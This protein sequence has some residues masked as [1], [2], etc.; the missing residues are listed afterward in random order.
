MSVKAEAAE[1]VE[2]RFWSLQR[3]QVLKMSRAKGDV[4]SEIL[5][6]LGSC[7]AFSGACAVDQVLAQC[8]Q[9][10]LRGGIALEISRVVR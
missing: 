8:A 4:Q 9:G 2:F 3:D 5:R 1:R 7:R 6:L 10:F